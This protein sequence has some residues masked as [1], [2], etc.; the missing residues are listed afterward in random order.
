MVNLFPSLYRPKSP[1]KSILLFFCSLIAMASTPSDAVPPSLSV[2]QWNCRSLHTNCFQLQ[3]HI[4]ENAFDILALQSV[5]TSRKALPFLQG[6]HY[7]PYKR[8]IDNK[9]RVA[10]YVRT[11]LSTSLTYIKDLKDGL[12]L[13]VDL[14]NNDQVVVINTYFNQGINHTKQIEWLKT[15]S[16]K[17][18]ILGDFNSHSRMWDP[19]VNIPDSGG[20]ILEDILEE[21]INICLKNDG[22]FTRI[23]DISGQKPS[24]ID[25]TMCSTSLYFNLS[26]DTLPDPLGSDHLPI[27]ITYDKQPKVFENNTGN[28][29]HYSKAD[30]LKFKNIL[31]NTKFS[32]DFTDPDGWYKTFQTTV[33]EAAANSIPTQ[34]TGCRRVNKRLLEWN[35]ECQASKIALR[36][37]T[38]NY[39]REQTDENEQA[40]AQARI[41]HNKNLANAQKNYWTRY[42]EDN[43]KSYKDCGIVY[44]KLN[45]IKGRY[46]PATK[47]LDVNGAR[48]TDP[49]SKA[50][51]LAETFASVS[52]T[53]SLS[54]KQQTFRQAEQQKFEKVSFGNTPDA[55]DKNFTMLE[56][57]KSLFSIKNIKKAAGADPLNYILI[58]QF[59]METKE[60]L[61]NFFNFI[62]QNGYVLDCWKEAQ[63]TAIQKPG[64]PAKD[65]SSYRPI[66]LTPHI[67][68]LYERLVSIRL[69]HFLEKNNVIPRCQSGFRRGR[70]CVENLMKLSS[71]V[72]KALMKR[73]PVMAAFFDIKRAFDTVWHEGLL[74]KL[75]SFGIS[76]N[77]YFFF[78]SFLHKRT[79]RV[80]IGSE[81]SD[82]HSLDMGIPQ[83]SIVA[84]TAF[85]IM[86]ADIV[87]LNFKNANISLYADD[88]VLWSTSK[89]RRTTTDR[90]NSCE[91]KI[92]QEN[93]DLIS[94]Y[95]DKNGFTLSPEKTVFMIFPNS[96]RIDK[97]THIFIDNQKIFVSTSVK[98]LGVTLDRGFTF[99]KHIHN[100]IDKTKKNLN[101]IKLLKREEGINN[102]K[103]IKLLINALIRSRLKYGE[104]IFCCANPT[105]LH[106]LQQC[107]TSII[108][109]ALN[110]PSH[111]DPILVYR[112]VGMIPLSLDR[113]QQTTKTIFRLGTQDNDLDEELQLS[114]NNIHDPGNKHRLDNHPKQFGRAVSAMNYV[115]PIVN[116]SGIG[117][118]TIDVQTTN[119]FFCRPWDEMETSISDSLC[120]LKKI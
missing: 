64:K 19:L 40:K 78:K 21:N 14:E 67:S 51:V 53:T 60:I 76:K 68:K 56:L 38:K 12:A 107:E 106:K 10:F 109:K 57:E 79:I 36:K 54:A 113:R 62:W 101:L 115:Q 33:M 75:Y 80:K 30:W 16:D 85:S 69:D 98:Y 43:V 41:T 23:P 8:V 3:Q 49:K 92:F 25:L 47:P 93:I 96:A 37:A 74:Q 112:E 90:F 13:T 39:S 116:A 72:K 15:L 44:K 9:V 95:M 18:I 89:Y 91:M 117:D 108:K 48:I 24:V 35:D 11:G 87:E 46:T 1:P 65:P 104:E 34:S 71:H 105:L 81:L 5:G 61:L 77:M 6:Y 4:N 45:K 119:K 22:S 52:Q 27:K 120:N 32:S 7:P 99:E 110:I 102:I 88:L 94:C 111:A 55:Y 103:N 70:S 73:R 100:L 63:V 58:K 82:R 29:F 42:F 20:K 66:S 17:Y 26:V 31:S 84:P 50:N 28:K 118:H 83:G 97:D 59:P 2:L 86:L 114:F